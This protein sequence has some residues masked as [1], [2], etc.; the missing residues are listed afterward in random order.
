MPVFTELLEKGRKKEA[1][2][3]ACALFVADLVVLGAI[4]VLFIARSRR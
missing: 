4:T 3:L 2:R 1:F